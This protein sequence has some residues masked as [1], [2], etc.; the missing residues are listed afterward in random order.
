MGSS[1]LPGKTLELIYGKPMLEHLVDRVRACD[2]IENIVLA[3][4]NSTED[5]ILVIEK[6]PEFAGKIEHKCFTPKSVSKI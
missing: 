4:T 3:T 1:R 5:D 2:A 6:H